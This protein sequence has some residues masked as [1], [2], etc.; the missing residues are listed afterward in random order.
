[1]AEK[2]VSIIG[3]GPA[4][5]YAAR[6][7]KLRRPDW[8][9][10]VH[11]RSTH[12]DSFGFG[13]SLTGRALA[14]FRQ[15]DEE[16]HQE[17]LALGVAAPSAE[18][19][20]PTGTV[21]IPG[22]SRGVAV[23]RRDLLGLL[24]RLCRASG[25]DLREGSTAD[26]DELR[27]HSD[28]VVVADGAGSPSRSRLREELGVRESFARDAFIWCA[29]EVPLDAATFV[30]IETEHGVYATHSYPYTSTMSGHVIEASLE[31]VQ[32]AGMSVGPRADG[33]SD[34]VALEY[35][36]EVFS[37]ILKGQPLIGNR[38]VW[39]RF[40][41]VSCE[42]WHHDRVVVIGDAAATAHM[43]LGSGTKH[44]MESAISLA[45]ALV[46]EDSVP[47]AFAR[48]E[49]W[50][51]PA[52]A[53]LQD[54]SFRSSLWW[55]SIDRRLDLAPSRLAVSYLTRA[56][57]M[58]LDKLLASAGG[59]TTDAATAVGGGATPPDLDPAAFERWVLE[60][61]LSVRQD[62]ELARRLIGPDTSDVVTVAGEREAREQRH[63]RPGAVVLVDLTVDTGDA[64]GDEAAAVVTR[65]RACLAAGAD[66]VRLVGKPTRDALLDRLALAERIRTTTRA[67]V[68]VS[69]PD[70]HRTDLVEGLLAGRLDLVEFPD[71]EG[72][73]R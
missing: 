19:R 56:G 45:D 61:P 35:L 4:G 58:S 34:M 39:G 53:E 17:I 36:S 46:A 42:R 7:M 68:A 64:W 25:V 59:L 12:D 66:G 14:S 18:F 48:Y 28:I 55:Q 37:E 6:L 24:V 65:A 3:G 69:G 33:G 51:R 11:E 27:R 10:T 2:I 38:S 8:S 44:A 9:V 57:A 26:V 20:L 5:L 1:M 70:E 41:W 16:S 54:R 67:T 15:A 72:E 60:R 43:S 30:P 21:R 40:R 32:A 62:V 52:T 63:L 31:T 49:Q 47:D 73:V 29:A 71:R 13:V 50:Q 23:A 22:F